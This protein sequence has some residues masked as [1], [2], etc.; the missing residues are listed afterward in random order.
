MSLKSYTCVI[1][2]VVHIIFKTINVIV[3]EPSR[4]DGQ[5]QA[6]YAHGLFLVVQ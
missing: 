6:Q 2:K 5:F 4:T 3:V 1:I